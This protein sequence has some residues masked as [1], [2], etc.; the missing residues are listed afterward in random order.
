MTY[1][2]F[3]DKVKYYLKSVRILKNH[4]S[5]DMIFSDTWVISKS[6][7]NDIEIIK[8]GLDG[9]TVLLSFV[10]PL[11]QEKV[12]LVEELIDNI[13]KTNREREE[14]DQ[15]FRSK[16]QELKKIFE[17]QKL[18]ELKNLKFDVDEISTYLNNNN[19]DSDIRQNIE[20]GD[21]GGVV[22]VETGEEKGGQGN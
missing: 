4:V 12:N 18:E 21:R 11:N 8:G 20:Q 10:C 3:L 17:K 9:N 5:F 6:K 16:V 14:K 13:I 2:S 22:T 7:T 19:E 1:F 15:L